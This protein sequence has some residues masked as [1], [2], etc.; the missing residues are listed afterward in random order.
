MAAVL[1]VVGAGRA[2]RQEA[3]IKVRQP[4]P[5]LLVY[6][7]EPAVLGCG[8]AAAGPGARRTERQGA[9]ATRRSR[10]IRLL[11]HPAE[12]ARARPEVLASGS[13]RSASA[14]AALDPAAVAATVEAGQAVV[15]AR[16][17]TAH[18][19]PRP[20][21]GPGRSPEAAGVRRRAR[22][23]STVVLDTSLTPELIQEGL[24]RDFVRGIQDARKRA[25]YRI[26]DTIEIAY[27]ADPEVA[28]AIEAHRHYVRSETL[29]TNLAGEA[30]A[31]ASDA[32]EP[33]SVAG[34]GGLS[35]PDG[36]YADQITVGDHHVRITLCPTRAAPT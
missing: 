19:S 26:E 11:R 13:T 31:G 16:P 7:R 21:R 2:A 24:A 10:A 1:E 12:P 34:P 28:A 17:P 4:L 9:R 15:A 14:L 32:V 23:R 27:A 30:S 22:P 36:W 3:A 8:P 5:A 6:S 33:E 29:A 20:E 18:V 35:F 25:G